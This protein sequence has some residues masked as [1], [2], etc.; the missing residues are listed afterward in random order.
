MVDLKQATRKWRTS[1]RKGRQLAKGSCVSDQGKRISQCFDT[2]C[3]L[4]AKQYNYHW[5]ARASRNTTCK[6][7][8]R[9]VIKKPKD[10][11][12]Q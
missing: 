9:H 8:V 6:A 4:E 5:P 7:V 2:L 3:S 11:E 10:P 12:L 1:S